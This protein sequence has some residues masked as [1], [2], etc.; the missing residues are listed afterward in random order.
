MFKITPNGPNRL[1]ILISGKI[2]EE[3][4]E[5]ALD[6]FHEK[7]H[8]IENGTMLYTIEDFK[9]PSLGAIAVEFTRLPQLYGLAKKFNR[10]AV[11]ADEGWIQKISELEALLIPGLEIK[12]FDRDDTAA[13]EAWLKH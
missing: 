1:D 11:L 4:M 12:A 8:D 5:R 9:I 13:A 7:A 3:E 2:R 10:A 6:E